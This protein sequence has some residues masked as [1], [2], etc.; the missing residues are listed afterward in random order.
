MR[1]GAAEI[2][3]ARGIAP[4]PQTA[5]AGGQRGGERSSARPAGLDGRTGGTPPQPA[6]EKQN[7]GDTGACC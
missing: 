4:P 1:P 6:R 7:P 2:K 5:G 3:I